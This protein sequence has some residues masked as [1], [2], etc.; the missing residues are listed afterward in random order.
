[1]MMMLSRLSVISMFLMAAPAAEA[2]SSHSS[3]TEAEWNKDSR[4]FEI[5]MKVRIADLQDAISAKQGKRLRLHTGSPADA[6][7]E[8]LTENFY[9]TFSEN[10]KCRLRWVG[11]ELE[12][13]DVW[14]Y[15]EAEPVADRRN[16]APINGQNAAQSG[17][18]QRVMTWDEL[19]VGDDASKSDFETTDQVGGRTVRIRDTVLCDIQ[20]DQTNLVTIRVAGVTQSLIF[21]HDHPA[22]TTKSANSGHSQNNA[23]P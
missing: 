4:R 7:L 9:V 12:L 6:I 23:Q 14:L 22:A 8:Y 13:H 15:F 3:V 20:P 10:Q 2:H 17:K 5:A 1:M 11:M 16:T 18:P 19:L 21:E